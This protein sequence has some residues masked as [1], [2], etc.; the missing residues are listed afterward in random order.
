MSGLS[1]IQNSHCVLTFTTIS[2]CTK[3]A[4]TAVVIR[5]YGP[6]TRNP[7]RK[8]RPLYTRMVRCVEVV[9]KVTVTDQC[10]RHNWC[11]HICCKISTG[12]ECVNQKCFILNLFVW[13]VLL[14][15]L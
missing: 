5:L 8:D 11:L 15:Y 1:I 6:L 9:V 2:L 14:I 13:C 7:V 3:S 10:R 4:D 12:E